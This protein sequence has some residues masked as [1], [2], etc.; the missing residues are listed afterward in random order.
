VRYDP[1]DGDNPKDAVPIS[2]AHRRKGGKHRENHA[3]SQESKNIRKTRKAEKDHRP[4]KEKKG[5]DK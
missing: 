4:K 3:R 5:K 1:P 2:G